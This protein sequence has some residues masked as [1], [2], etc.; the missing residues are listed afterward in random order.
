VGS[1]STAYFIGPEMSDPEPAEPGF[2]RD[3]NGALKRQAARFA[4]ACAAV[5]HL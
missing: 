2:Y 5:V 4:E 1:S 3:A